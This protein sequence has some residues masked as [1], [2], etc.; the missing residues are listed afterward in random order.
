VKPK[1]RKRLRVRDPN[2]APNFKKKAGPMKHRNEPR[3]GTRNRQREYL[4]EDD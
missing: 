2:L 4:E 3:G 1:R